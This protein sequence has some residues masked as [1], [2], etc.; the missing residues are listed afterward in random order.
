MSPGVNYCERLRHHVARSLHRG[1]KPPPLPKGIGG[2]FLPGGTA[3]DSG[4]IALHR[5]CA[6]G[7]SVKEIASPHATR[8]DGMPNKLGTRIARVPYPWS[9]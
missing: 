9:F 1:T 6:S 3:A 7:F 4:Y 5:N 8:G 2:T